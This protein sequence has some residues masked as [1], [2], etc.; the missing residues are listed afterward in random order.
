[1]RGAELTARSQAAASVVRGPSDA[2]DA[3]RLRL[4]LRDSAGRT[5]LNPDLVAALRSRLEIDPARLVTLEGI[6]GSFCEGLDLELLPLNGEEPSASA[7]A[8]V[9]LQE[10]EALLAAIRST[11]R[12]VIALV[13]G[14]AVG[15]GLGIAAA[16]DLVIASPRASF[17]LPEA[18]MGLIPAVV[19]PVVAQRIGI[20]RARRLALGSPPL[21]VAQALEFGLVD[22]I[23]ED[24]EAAFA[25]HARRFVRMDAR[26]IGTLKKLVATHFEPSPHYKAD[27][28]T[29]FSE[30]LESEE[31]RRRI[32]RFYAGSAPWDEEDAS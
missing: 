2:V 17:A 1:M 23:A 20:A 5:R 14:P 26:A 28:R 10:L 32:T 16:A 19:F 4:S 25:R 21:D 30:L 27:A 13:D 29:S 3:T 6:P 9:A 24:L 15:G 18:V 22:E 12:P 8:E 31:T 11:P 7:W